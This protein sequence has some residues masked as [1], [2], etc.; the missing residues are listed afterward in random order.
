[1][2]IQVEIWANYIAETLYK[3]NSFMEQTMN[4][5][6]FV[7]GKTVHSPQSGD[8]VD[9]VT[10]RSVF[11]AAVTSRTD[12]TNDWDIDDF[13]TNPIRIG[14]AEMVELSYNKIDSV[15]SASRSALNQKIADS[16][17]FRWSPT[18]T[19]NLRNSGGVNRN[20]IR[21]SGTKWMDEAAE[22]VFSSAYLDLATG[23]RFNFS[24]SDI[25]AAKKLFDKQNVP[26]EDR[27]MLLS[28]DAID[29][30]ASEIAITQFRDSLST[31]DMTTGTIDKL[32]GFK[33]HTRSSVVRYN[34][35]ETPAAKAPAAAGAA[36][37]NDAAIFWQ[38][39]MLLRAE[40]DIVVFDNQARA[41]YFGNIYSFLRRF[42]GNIW[43]N[44][45]VGVGAIVQSVYVP[46]GG[47]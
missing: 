37:D 39:S 44:D 10:N 47:V 38:K 40:G 46:G 43:R 24:L 45:E 4:H 17:I 13:S 1:M 3:D 8:D 2:A 5:S 19:A 6:E 25:K 21:T 16:A 23:Y 7:N 41:E 30:I 36:D 14:N 42:G 11:P 34:N 12:T 33:I 29:Q 15:L 35:V 22:K 9:V 26:A 28:A 20:I 18:G 32:L 31:F 27:H